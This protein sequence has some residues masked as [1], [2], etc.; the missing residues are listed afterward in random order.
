VQESLRPMLA[1][2]DQRGILLTRQFATDLPAVVGHKGQLR[3]VFAN[4]L[5]NA[6][7]AMVPVNERRHALRVIT[8]H[9]RDQIWVTIEDSGLGIEPE[10]LPTL[11]TAF[12]STKEFGMGLGLSICQMIVD[13]HHGRLSVSSDLG[14][15]TRFEI[16]LPASAELG[17]SAPLEH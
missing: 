1:E 2:L 11:F 17:S 6:M 3:E 10:R 8:S 16:Q 5:Q 15:W 13:R 12:V 9:A 4:I 14:Q 7:D